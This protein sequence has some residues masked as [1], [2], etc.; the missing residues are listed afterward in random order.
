MSG[1]SSSLYI[2]L[3]GIR[4]AQLGLNV[5]GNNIANVNTP[6]YSRQRAEIRVK[7]VATQNGITLGSGSDVR[8]VE[9]L[10]ETFANKI[11]A[12]Q[13]ARFA[14]QGALASGL[15]NMEALLAE[16]D[17]SGIGKA[18]ADFFE[19]LERTALR[20]SDLGVR[21]ELLALGENLAAEIRNR[22][23]DLTDF[24][25]AANFEVEA[26]VD[27]VN[28][29]TADIVSINKQ[30]NSQSDPAQDLID[31]RN[32]AV[33]ELSKL[34]GVETF[35]LANNQLQ[36]NIQGSNQ[37]LVG[38][39]IRNTLEAR[40]NPANNNYYDVAL[41]TNSASTVITASLQT[42]QLGA[43]LQL[44]DSEIPDIR[45]KLDRLA[46][47]LIVEFNTVHQTG[48]DLNGNVNLRFFDPDNATVLGATAVGTIDPNR[49]AGM[50]GSIQLSNDLVDPLNPAAGFDPSRVAL[51]ATG[52]AGDNGT[53][54]QLA[55]LRQSA[56]VIDDDL[57]G[58]PTNDDSGSY[59]RFYSGVLSE[60][61]RAVR[62]AGDSLETQE[63]L[64]E[65]ARERRD[66]ISA[67]SLDEEAVQLTQFQRAFE[68]SSRFL[69]IVNQLTAEIL[70]RVG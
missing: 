60:L 17:D 10:R 59:E 33:S 65:Q 58:D 49:Y 5:A 55:A 27:R 4:T 36:V 52:A 64:L 29:L 13:E 3:S 63:A 32:Q 19:G 20:P 68:A 1:L 26:L 6:G 9:G 16:S 45:R 50:A 14:Y 66:G 38:R 31:Q 12:E 43:K 8:L 40:I 44:R 18:M 28:D 35:E 15:N 70:N 46:A 56:N 23:S 2:G 54:L 48:T 47:G 53:A 62:I 30:I 7:G 34:V 22:D 41:N 21:R 11:L 39:Q 37:I 24:Q 51:S 25:N 42:G 69:G 57:D 67:V 61:G